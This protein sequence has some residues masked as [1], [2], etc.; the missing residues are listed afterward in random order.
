MFV[1]PQGLGHVPPAEGPQLGLGLLDG[2]AQT[3]DADSHAD[4]FALC[5]LHYGKV[6]FVEVGQILVGIGLHLFAVQFAV[7]I[8]V[9]IRTVHHVQ[10]LLD[11][12]TFADFALFVELAQAEAVAF[13]H[14]LGNLEIL[15]DLCLMAFLGNG[16][17]ALYP[18]HFL[19]VTQLTHVLGIVGIVVDAVHRGQLVVAVGEH[20][21]QVHIGESQRAHD[22]VHA[23]FASPFLYCLQQ[24]LGNFQVI[25]E[26]YP[27]EA[28][29]F[30]IPMFV[31]TA[32]DD[33]SHASHDLLAAKGQEALHVA[34]LQRGILLG[35]EGVQ[36]VFQKIGYGIRTILVQFPVEANEFFHF[37]FRGH[38]SYGNR[39]V[40][41]FHKAKSK[42]L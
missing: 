31:G 27:S 13:L 42:I 4:D 38:G 7:T 36:R 9:G 19:L 41:V 5:G 22:G 33:G 1:E 29:V 30:L 11:V 2:A 17:L 3:G 32:V 39:G 12:A 24:F 37:P 28:Y 21:F 40:V 26:I 18:S 15:F 25:D 16:N 10:N 20:A 35:I 6:T 34:E 23:P 14:H 8:Q